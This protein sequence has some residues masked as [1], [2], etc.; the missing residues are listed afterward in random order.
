MYICQFVGHEAKGLAVVTIG[1]K[2]FMALSAAAGQ[3]I[4]C[5]L[6]SGQVLVGLTIVV[7]LMVRG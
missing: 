1:T 6:G 4:V 5:I 2:G 7:M 3:W